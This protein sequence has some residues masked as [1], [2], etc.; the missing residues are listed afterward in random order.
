MM[1]FMQVVRICH[2]RQDGYE[3]W[4]AHLK[5]QSK[6][7]ELLWSLVLGNWSWYSKNSKRRHPK[8]YLLCMSEKTLSIIK[9]QTWITEIGGKGFSANFQSQILFNEEG[10]SPLS[11]DEGSLIYAVGLPPSLPKWIC[12]HLLG[13]YAIRVRVIIRLVIG[14]QWLYTD[15]N[16]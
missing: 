14:G 11:S 12:D 6:Y 5:Q 7:S 16:F 1:I 2:Q 8:A 15:T 3:C 13:D 9:S 4:E 10:L